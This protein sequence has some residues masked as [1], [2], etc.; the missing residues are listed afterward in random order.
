MAR[1]A[2]KIVYVAISHV[3][4]HVQIMAFIT[5]QFSMNGAIEWEREAT[6]VNV[7]ADVRKVAQ[8][9]PAL[10]PVAG[11]RP[12]SRDE[13][14][15]EL[16]DQMGNRV[17]RNALRDVGGVLTYDLDHAKALAVATIRELRAP[18]LDALDK[19]WMRAT[20]QGDAASAAD[21]E[22]KR[23]VL[24]DQPAQIDFA[25]A[26]SVAEIHTAL[27]KNLADTEAALTA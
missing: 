17:Y 8:S 12:I 27:T 26:Q 6:S 23:Q 9:H 16:T 3:S 15:N 13:I 4:G 7:D 21:V 1:P 10:G 18:M 24:R 11:W 2:P 19:R 22:A 20:G 14:P 5:V 25:A